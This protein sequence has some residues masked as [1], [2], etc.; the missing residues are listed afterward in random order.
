MA[1]KTIYIEGETYATEISNDGNYCGLPSIWCEIKGRRD[2]LPWE[3]NARATTYINELLQAPQTEV[4]S[5]AVIEMK[6]TLQQDEGTTTSTLVVP[7]G[8]RGSWGAL[9]NHTKEEVAG[10]AYV[11]I[12][13][14]GVGKSRSLNYLIREIISKHRNKGSLPPAIVFEHR[15][16]QFVWLFVPRERE[17]PQSEYEA[18]S[19]SLKDF[20]A[21]GT[22]VLFDKRN[23]YIVDSGK[24][25][26]AKTPALITAKTIYSCPPDYRHFSELK[27]HLQNGGTYYV[28][29]WKEQE[30]IDA[31]PFVIGEDQ[32]QALLAS[33]PNQS[34]EEIARQRAGEVGAIPRRVF[35][36]QVEY[37]N[38][39]NRLE[40]AMKNNEEEIISV[41]KW[42]AERIAAD[43]YVDKPLSA[44]FAIDVATDLET[45]EPIYTSC[46]AWFV[47]N[48]ARARA[49]LNMAQALH[50]ALLL[51]FDGPSNAGMEYEKLV[52][53]MLTQ[54]GF[55]GE[56]EELGV[57]NPKTLK[58]IIEPGGTWLQAGTGL[59]DRF[60]TAVKSLT[61]GSTPVIAGGNVFGIDMADRPNRG[62]N[63]LMAKKKPMRM[64]TIKRL[65]TGLELKEEEMH[66]VHLVPE[67]H[68]P[69][70]PTPGHLHWYRA[71]VPP[72]RNW[73][74]F[75]RE[76]STLRRL[77][78]LFR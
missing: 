46:V 8:T 40:N 59:W 18:Y 27:K 28:P 34:L 44:V 5:L 33:N 19:V 64:A 26:E 1:A 47:S 61:A 65:L 53:L 52:A 54:H 76:F 41:L 37:E 57:A 56:M 67:G 71:I 74:P 38:F 69:K 75:R 43:K 7:S 29:V 23:Y 24:A 62:F 50:D 39:K 25:E 55:Q 6:T 63:M 10:Q 60:L 16:D 32:K 48:Y 15:N 20:A 21:T 68:S 72:P 78:R 4:G 2:S 45:Q 3:R 30:I 12:G 73:K 58:L 35:S 70:L 11:V 66:I 14:P 49:S 31:I 17:N 9:L 51:D 42:G 36:S 22:A 77:S 13:T